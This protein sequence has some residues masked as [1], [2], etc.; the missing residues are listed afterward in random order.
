MCRYKAISEISQQNWSRMNARSC[1]LYAMLLRIEVWPCTKYKRKAWELNCGRIVFSSY[2]SVFFVINLLTAYTHCRPRPHSKCV[3]KSSNK[4]RW[5][6]ATQ[7]HKTRAWGHSTA[8][9]PKCSVVG[10]SEL[11]PSLLSTL[12]IRSIGPVNQ[13]I[14]RA[15][16]QQDSWASVW[17]CFFWKVWGFHYSLLNWEASSSLKS[18][19]SAVH[20]DEISLSDSGNC[21]ALYRSYSREKIVFFYSKIYT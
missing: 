21:P 9:N 8:P 19:I 3:C 18:S 11:Q 13:P 14:A 10:T 17:G 5:R 12:R 6:R 20:S 7:N 16:S 15:V 2:Y 4:T 1:L